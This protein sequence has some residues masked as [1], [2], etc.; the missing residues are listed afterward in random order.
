[1]RK[2]ARARGAACQIVKMGK[3]ATIAKRAASSDAAKRLLSTNRRTRDMSFVVS[4]FEWVSVTVA[5]RRTGPRMWRRLL[6]RRSVESTTNCH[7]PRPSRRRPAHS[8][9]PEVQGTYDAHWDPSKGLPVP[10]DNRRRCQDQ[11]NPARRR[12]KRGSLLAVVGGS[13]LRQAPEFRWSG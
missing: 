9:V 8:R 11:F 10:T 1:L 5:G 4:V 3:S 6:M 2:A 7:D 12:M 13:I